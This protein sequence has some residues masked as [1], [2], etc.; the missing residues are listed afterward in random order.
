MLNV[1]KND[2][3]AQILVYFQNNNFNGFFPNYW[4]MYYF[5]LKNLF[6]Y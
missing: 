1:D 5:K 4:Y 3:N 2:N 6:F